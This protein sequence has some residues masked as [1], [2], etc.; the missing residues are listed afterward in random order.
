MAPQHARTSFRLW[1]LTFHK[2]TLHGEAALE[3][4]HP[5]LAIKTLRTPGCC[6]G[7]L[8]HP[9][10]A[11]W[12]RNKHRLLNFFFSIA[13]GFGDQVTFSLNHTFCLFS[14]EADV[15]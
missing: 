1:M 14:L 6:V 3:D 7:A 11:A 15:S 9:S 4:E 2:P 10:R 8:S 12:K 5:S 13:Y